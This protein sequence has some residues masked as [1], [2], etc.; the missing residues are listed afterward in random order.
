LRRRPASSTLLLLMLIFFISYLAFTS[1]PYNHSQLLN[2]PKLSVEKAAIFA[3]FLFN[4]GEQAA[5]ALLNQTT[6]MSIFDFI[7][8]NPGLHFRALSDCLNVPFGVLQYHLSLLVNHGLILVYGD[9]RYR[10]FFESKK[11]AE[12]EMKTISALRHET[13]GKILIALLE[14]PQTTHREL[15]AKLGISSQALSWQ[16][17]RLAKM[18]FVRRNFDGLKAKYSL[19]ETTRGAVSRLAALV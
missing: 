18:G 5:S 14:K 8:D 4:P 16:M 9:G 13:S 7:R 6:R 12:A 3:S 10:R 19:D 2:V 11:F 15:T 17:N 1:A